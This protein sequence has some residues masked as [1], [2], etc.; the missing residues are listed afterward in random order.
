MLELR[1]ELAALIAWNSSGFECHEQIEIDAVGHRI[2]RMAE[3]DSKDSRDRAAQ[4]RHGH[5][6]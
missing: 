6:H 5:L 2:M 1:E 4:L 3:T